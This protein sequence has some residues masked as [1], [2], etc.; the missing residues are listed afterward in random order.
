MVT[1]NL[2]TP[3]RVGDMVHYVPLV[4]EIPGCRAA[5][6]TGLHIDPQLAT[7]MVMHT[8]GVQFVADVRQA[9]C[10]YAWEKFQPGTWHLAGHV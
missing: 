1:P 10:D 5:V 2:S 9:E 7:L 3:P 4:A 6:V 8:T